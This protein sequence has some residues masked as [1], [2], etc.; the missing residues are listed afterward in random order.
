MTANIDIIEEMAIDAEISVLNALCEC[1]Q[2]QIILS[3]QSYVFQESV[4]ERDPNESKIK[5]ILLLPLRLIGSLIKLLK[6]F[7]KMCRNK[8]N[9]MKSKKNNV[10]NGEFDPKFSTLKPRVEDGQTYITSGIDID[11]LNFTIE[12]FDMSDIDKMRLPYKIYSQ[13]EYTVPDYSSK[14]EKIC[15]AIEKSIIPK[16]QDKL[17][18]YNINLN[19]TRNSGASDDKN[20]RDKI[21]KIEK[22]ISDLKRVLSGWNNVSKTISNELSI[23]MN[24]LSQNQNSSKDNFTFKSIDENAFRQ[25]IRDKDYLA[26]KVSTVSTMLDDPTFERGETMKA[27]QILKEQVPEIFEDEVKLDYEERLEKSA[28][29]KRYFTKL[30][31]WFQENFAIS[32]I[33]YIREVGRVVHRDTAEAYN[34]S[35]KMGGSKRDNRKNKE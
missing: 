22:D 7:V 31:Y 32:R 21:H 20:N 11:L 19:N 23:V 6:R 29:D 15:N 8:I 17:D 12:N 25:A 4:F 13:K 10:S 2:K 1:Y 33:S 27:I 26:L 16:L 34:K 18:E 28:W 24:L 35:K 9:Q 5:T 3:E 14:V 30:T